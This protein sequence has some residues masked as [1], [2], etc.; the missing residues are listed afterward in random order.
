VLVN[1][2]GSA[3]REPF[4]DSA[5]RHWD[6]AIAGNFGWLLPAVH[7][8]LPLLRASA[9]GASII[10]FTSIEAHRAAPGFAVYA[11]M[12]AAL[13][14]FTRTLAVELAPEGVRVNAIAPD[15]VVTPGFTRV[16]AGDADRATWEDTPLGRASA[17]LAVPA[18]RRGEPDDVG[19]AV[20]FLASELSAYVTGQT[21]HPD[22][23]ALASSGWSN[24]PEIGFRNAPPP[25]VVA[26]L[27][28][29]QDVSSSPPSTSSTPPVT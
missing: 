12:K 17:R 8:C 4:A 10:N 28:D 29:A 6:A 13:T 14:S 2:V 1:V 25:G 19:S 21:L 18:G 3:V 20:L 11:A 24:W 22:G 15:M 7:A 26:G 16:V 27:L 5:P 23:G 9:R